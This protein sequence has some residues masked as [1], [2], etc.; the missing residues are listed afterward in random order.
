MTTFTLSTTL[1]FNTIKNRCDRI[2]KNASGVIVVDIVG[3]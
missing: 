3:P 1:T 2:Q